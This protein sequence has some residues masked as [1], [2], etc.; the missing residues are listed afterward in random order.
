MQP[1]RCATEAIASL[2]DRRDKKD[3]QT[4]PFGL[5]FIEKLKPVQFTWDR[6]VLDRSDKYNPNNGKTR[7]GFIA[8]DFQEAMPNGENSI[9]D[10]VNEYNPDRIEAKY[11][12]LIPILTKAIQELQEKVKSLEEQLNIQKI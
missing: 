2:S 9:L 11:S 7:L 5:N 8:Q 10:L 4:C 6:R 1:L 12:N 3:I